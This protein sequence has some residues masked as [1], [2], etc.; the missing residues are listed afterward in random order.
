MEG[1]GPMKGEVCDLFNNLDSN[2]NYSIQDLSKQRPLRPI[3][4]D[5]LL[6]VSLVFWT[7]NT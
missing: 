7:E 2:T 1:G 3:K 5:T 6:G 4:K